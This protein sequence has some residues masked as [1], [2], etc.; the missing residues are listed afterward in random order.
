MQ[1]I[2][3]ILA[4][5]LGQKQQYIENVVNLIDEGN[6]IPFIARYRKEMHGAMDDTTLRNLE[7]RLTYLRNLQQRRDEV[8]KSIENQG[9]LTEELSAAIDNASTM[10]EVEDLYRPYKQKRRTRGSIAREKGLD[11]LAQAIFAQDGQDIE[12]LAQGFL[13]EEKGVATVEEAIAGAS[14]IIAEN[15]SDDAEIRKNLRALVMRRGSLVSKADDPG[16]DTVYKLYYDFNQSITRLMDHQILAIN[17]GEKEGILKVSITLP[18]KSVVALN[19]LSSIKYAPQDFC[20]E[21]REIEFEGEAHYKVAKDARHPFIIHMQGMEIK[22]LG[23]EFNVINRKKEQTAEVALLNG[24]VML[25]SLA[26]GSTYTMKPNE[27]VVV[28]KQTGKM[29]VRE[30]SHIEDACAWQKKQLVFRDAS[31]GRVIRSLEKNYGVE[32]AV[33]MDTI[34]PFTG[35]LPN[36]SLTEALQI[37]SEAYQVKFSKTPAGK[38]VLR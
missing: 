5:E 26:N 4:Q 24:S 20:K 27:I 25:T 17:R 28:N 30:A 14:D 29:D 11:P 8:K 3:E 34:E 22:V 6:T 10:T 1:S 18:D 9:K 33:E 35:T 2:V 31:L 23:T 37:V 15:L 38:Y 12:K 19:S 32:I 21:N 16:T 7:T 13:D 36:N